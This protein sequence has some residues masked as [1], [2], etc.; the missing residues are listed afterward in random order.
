[1]A[2]KNRFQGILIQLTATRQSSL[3][4][5]QAH[6]FKKFEEKFVDL[7]AILYIYIRAFASRWVH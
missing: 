1:M 6:F 7:S 3:K 2:F 5:S 4:A